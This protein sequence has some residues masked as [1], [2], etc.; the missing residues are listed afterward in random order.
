MLIA[1]KVADV[2]KNTLV[3]LSPVYTNSIDDNER[4]I[5]AANPKR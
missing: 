5:K 2:I 4:P 1:P 3:T